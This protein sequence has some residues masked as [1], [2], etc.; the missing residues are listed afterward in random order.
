[1]NNSFVCGYYT[2]SF[3]MDWGLQMC[4]QVSMQTEFI[5]KTVKKSSCMLLQARPS[6]EKSLPSGWQH[7]FF[8]NLYLAFC[9]DEALIDIHAPSACTYGNPIPSN[10]CW[11]LWTDNKPHLLSLE[12]RAERECSD[13]TMLLLNAL[14][15]ERLKI[16][17]IYYRI[18]PRLFCM[19]PSSSSN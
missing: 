10:S 7:M 14:P 1:M 12:C 5:S 8:S 2:F 19:C 4:W 11:L 17:T 6:L 18:Q 15:P 3:F 9:N 16:T 13:G